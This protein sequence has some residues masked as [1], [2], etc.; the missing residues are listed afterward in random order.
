MTAPGSRIQPPPPRP[1]PDLLDGFRTA[2]TA[3]ISD[4]MS[5][6]VGAVGLQPF[7][8][9][10][11]LV[12]TALTVRTR[13]GDNLY[14]HKAFD[15]ARPGDV[16][17]ID[18]GGDVSQAL[19]GEIMMTYA[20]TLGIAGFVIDGA[21]RDAAAFRAGDF[22]CFARAAIHKGPYKNG[23]GEI[24]VPVTIGGMVVAPGDIIVGDDDGVVAVPAAAAA[25]VLQGVRAQEAREAKA[26]ADIRAGTYDRSWLKAAFPQA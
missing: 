23:P 3:L 18:G 24:N 11:H 1:A 6:I 13:A 2:A 12:G 8:R 16:L 4:N 25:A 17:V 20:K 15:F 19:V 26:L 14:I 5:R 10:G 9:A 22:P 7:H 21:I